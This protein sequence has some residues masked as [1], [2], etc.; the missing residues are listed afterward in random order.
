[1]QLEDS[2][3]FQQRP[4]LSTKFDT[5]VYN[6]WTKPP[7]KINPNNEG[8]GTRAKLTKEEY[9]TERRKHI[10]EGM[11]SI[12]TVQDDKTAYCTIATLSNNVTEAFQAA[13]HASNCNNLVDKF[14]VRLDKNKSKLLSNQTE[15]W[16]VQS[17]FI[18]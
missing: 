5:L 16:Y 3:L 4:E 18:L 17:I 15:E 1:M 13:L 7:A 2:R 9:V 14:H 6:P 10:L 8:K 11:D 12:T